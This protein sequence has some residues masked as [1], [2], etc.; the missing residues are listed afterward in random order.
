MYDKLI[1]YYCIYSF[2]RREG[3]EEIYMECSRATITSIMHTSRSWS[4][5][6]CV[7]RMLGKW[8]STRHRAQ[9]LKQIYREANFLHYAPA[10]ADRVFFIYG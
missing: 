7:T 4:M 10:L 2:G 8:W 9:E 1:W 3:H 6:R 5:T